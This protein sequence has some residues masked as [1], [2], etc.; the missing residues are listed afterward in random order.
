LCAVSSHEG[1]SLCN[2]VAY[3]P[4]TEGRK[5]AIVFNISYTLWIYMRFLIFYLFECVRSQ[6]P[7]AATGRH[8]HQI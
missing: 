2:H 6:G 3:W 7:A 4:G 1:T 8:A 5:L